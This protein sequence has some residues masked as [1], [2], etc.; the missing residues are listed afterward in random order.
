MDQEFIKNVMKLYGN[1]LFTEGFLEFAA[2]MQQF[3]M[4][5]ARQSWATNHRADK[6]PGNAAEIFEQMIAFY[7]QLGFVPKTQHEE[8]LKENERLGRENEFLKNTIREMNVKIYTDGSLQVQQ[9][10]KE[11]AHKQM[12]MSAEMASKFFDLF[13]PAGGE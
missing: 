6:F 9:L 5:A 12:E 8:V 1:P 10:W 11:T 4:E 7:S 3:G 13:K 2:R